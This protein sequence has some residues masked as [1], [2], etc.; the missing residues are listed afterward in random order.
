MNKTYLAHFGVPG[1]KWG[2]R[3]KYETSGTYNRV[4]N[5]KQGKMASKLKRRMK[6]DDYSH[7]FDRYVNTSNGITKK[8][9]A[10]NDMYRK[11][12]LSKMSSYNTA[13]KK[14]KASKQELKNAKKA[15]KSEVKKNTEFANKQATKMDKILYNDATRKRT[16][17]LM[18]K[19]KNMSYEE[20]SK[21]AKKEAWRNT[22]LVGLTAVAVYDIAS[23]GKVRN[24]VK[25]TA[26]K[27]GS[28][29]NP[30]NMSAGGAKF[31]K[32]ARNVY[33]SA[34]H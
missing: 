22:A 8:G 6:W 23:G 2:V 16:G 7:S 13:N 21:K 4:Q 33:S 27:A 9:K 26:M 20:A 15:Y 5:A 12:M 17:A 31:T 14:Y 25:G 34:M 29:I 18:T 1:M 19:Y 32:V 3:K 10:R 11:D 30:K 28:H 24:A